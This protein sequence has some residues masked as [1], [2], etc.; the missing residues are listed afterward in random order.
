MV[1]NAMRVIGNDAYI[2]RYEVMEAFFQTEKDDNEEM[3]NEL[4]DMLNVFCSLEREKKRNV[5]TLPFNI[6]TY[7]NAI[8]YIKKSL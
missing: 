4:N 2:S 3:A 5:I 7:K 6:E 1:G 8:E